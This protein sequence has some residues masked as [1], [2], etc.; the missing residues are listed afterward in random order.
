MTSDG[1]APRRALRLLADPVVGWFFT[2]RFTSVMGAWMHNIAAA[3]FM[4]ELT[5]SATM[6]GAA[7]IAQFLPVLLLTPWSGVLADRGDRRRQ[8][9]YGGIVSTAGS[10]ALALWI[11]VGSDASL[12]WAVLGTAL[13]VGIGFALEG[14]PLQSLLPS[15]ARPSELNALVALNSMPLT[16]ARAAGPAVGAILIKEVGAETAFAA[17]A[18]GQFSFVVIMFF[19]RTSGAEEPASNGAANPGLLPG[20]PPGPLPGLLPGLLWIWRDRAVLAML[21]GTAAIGIGADPSVTLTP[22]LAAKFNGH[23]V[24]V[25]A[26]ASSFGLGAAAGFLLLGTGR[27]LMGLTRLAPAG[28]AVMTLGLVGAGL[29]PG[30]ATAMCALAVAGIGMTLAGTALTTLILNRS[31]AGLRG[32]VMAI[33]FVAMLGTRPMA[34]GVSG[35]LTDAVNVTFAL[36]CVAAVVLVGAWVVRPSRILN[37]RP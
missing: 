34:A 9:I 17:S 28:L 33:W 6:V 8:V 12:P 21:L 2:G 20:L 14:P 1:T 29:S 5:G 23:E 24:M 19:L 32:R 31:P 36:C 15:L 27:R 18:V 11:V 22:S 25:G 35:A 13:L 37:D 26:L 16:F 4:F 30:A 10:A 7:S 3:I